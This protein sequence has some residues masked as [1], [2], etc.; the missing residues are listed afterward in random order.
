LIIIVFYFPW[1]I[2]DSWK[3]NTFVNCFV[4]FALLDSQ[5]QF[6]TSHAIFNSSAYIQHVHRIIS[7]KSSSF[8]VRDVA[9]R[10]TFPMPQA[11]KPNTCNSCFEA[12]L[13]KIGFGNGGQCCAKVISL[14]HS[15]C[16]LAQSWLT[17]FWSFRLYMAMAFPKMRPL[18]LA[19]SW[20]RRPL[21]EVEGPPKFGF[22]FHQTMHL[23]Q[24]RSQRPFGTICNNASV[25][26]T[27][28]FDPTFV[29]SC[30]SEPNELNKGV[31]MA[32]KLGRFEVLNQT[33][34]ISK[35]KSLF[36]NKKILTLKP[37]T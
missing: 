24:M 29:H 23:L 34:K 13:T 5:S 17:T 33:K 37:Y 2:L 11:L 35:I 6:L 4:Q 3:S 26:F 20:R 19:W 25:N 1:I 22:F 21:T 28:H 18:I 8:S 9:S 30:P 16:V 7:C 12:N 14:S 36:C 31:L 15:G 10:G 32:K 27:F